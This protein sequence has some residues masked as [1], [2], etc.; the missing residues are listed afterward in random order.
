MISMLVTG[1]ALAA[2][3]SGAQG[4]QYAAVVSAMQVAAAQAGISPDTFIA[5]YNAAAA[6]NVSGFSD[7]QLAAACQ[8]LSSLSSYKSV[9]PDYNTVYSNGCST[10]LTSTM[11]ASSLPSTGTTV[12][13]L[14][15]SGLIGIAAASV[16]LRRARR[17]S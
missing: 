12:A 5:I 14:I 1:T 3:P 15:A 11:Q 6:G 8:V 4:N 13:L 17:Q 10:R 9:L 7:S 2:F 16:L